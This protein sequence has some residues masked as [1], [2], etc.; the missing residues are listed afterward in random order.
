MQKH[1]VLTKEVIAEQKCHLCTQIFSTIKQL[2]KHVSLEHVQYNC[3]ECSF[4]AGTKM[5][6]AKHMNLS[7][8]KIGDT[9]EETLKCGKF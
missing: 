4:Q 9:E 6:L 1:K 5:V 7:H 8:K 3:S 2:E